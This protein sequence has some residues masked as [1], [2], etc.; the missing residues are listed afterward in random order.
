MTYWLQHFT[1]NPIGAFVDLVLLAVLAALL[2]YGFIIVRA[3][4]KRL[5]EQ[6]SF[7]VPHHVGISA[8]SRSACPSV[9]VIELGRSL[10]VGYSATDVQDAELVCKRRWLRR[11]LRGLVIED[12]PAWNGKTQIAARK[13][14]TS[15]SMRFVKAVQIYNGTFLDRSEASD[16]LKFVLVDRHNRRVVKIGYA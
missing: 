16:P 13:A 4:F 5:L 8:A 7:M 6:A 12:V 9:Y 15:E 3:W 10:V 1:D 2:L 14:N 11:G